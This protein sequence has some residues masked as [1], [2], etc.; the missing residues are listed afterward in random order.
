MTASPTLN[1]V[2]SAIETLRCPRRLTWGIA[3]VG[4]LT[5]I[6]ASAC[7]PAPSP[8]PA[9]ATKLVNAYADQPWTYTLGGPLS[10]VTAVYGILQVA[11][12][13]D[14]TITGVN[15]RLTT[16]QTASAI[17][18]FGNSYIA[19]VHGTLGEARGFAFYSGGDLQEALQGFRPGLAPWKTEVTASQATLR[20]GPY[21]LLA[22]V[23][24]VPSPSWSLGEVDVAY[25]VD[26]GPTH[27]LALTGIGLQVQTP[28][29]SQ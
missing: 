15:A 3:I 7:A 2:N 28:L 27:T 8:K 11:G 13:G 6:V 17:A 12:P 24:D 21:Y 18:E 26:S 16:S 14:V 29:Q 20:T 22:T 19:T 1:R 9:P 10:Q 23:F 25:R 4:A 5:T